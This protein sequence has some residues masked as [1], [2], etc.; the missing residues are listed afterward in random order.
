MDQGRD[1]IS[2]VW[3]QLLECPTAF[4]EFLQENNSANSAATRSLRSGVR[5][6]QVLIMSPNSLPPRGSKTPRRG[7]TGMSLFLEH[8]T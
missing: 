2:E 1:R 3:P 5:G 6:L 7:L 4:E 8:R